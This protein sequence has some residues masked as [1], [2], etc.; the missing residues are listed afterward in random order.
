MSEPIEDMKY[1]T[2]KYN[3][4]RGEKVLV[5]RTGY[6]GEIGFEITVQMTWF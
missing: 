3:H 1:F 6:T 2:F 5:S 4:Y